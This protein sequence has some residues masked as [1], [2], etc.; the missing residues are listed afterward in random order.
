[1]IYIGL[2][3]LPALLLGQKL[4]GMEKQVQNLPVTDPA[5]IPHFQDVLHTWVH[6]ALPDW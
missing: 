2:S 1:M 3:L 5:L 4:K 6:K